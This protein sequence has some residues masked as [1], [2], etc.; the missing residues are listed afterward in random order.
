MVDSVVQSARGR[1]PC[2][3]RN[4]PQEASR[5]L[6]M[7]FQGAGVPAPAG[8]GQVN[9]RGNTELYQEIISYIS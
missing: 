9:Y 3:M 7:E 1:L 4:V 6:Q 2:E 5:L 8:P